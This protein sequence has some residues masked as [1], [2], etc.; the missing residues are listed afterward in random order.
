[1]TDQSRMKTAPDAQRA[2]VQAS[3]QANNPIRTAAM[4]VSATIILA[5]LY[6]GRGV[7]VP[8][9]LALLLSFA[10]NP[11]VSW[12]RRSGMPR[13][14]AVSAVMLI[15][16]CVIA[17]FGLIL[18][19]QV[20]TLS[21]ELPTYQSTIQGKLTTLRDTLKSPG[22]FDG[23]L[24]TLGTIQNEVEA[25]QSTVSVQRVEVLPVPES[26]LK[27]A[28]TWLA[29]SAEPLATAGIVFVFVFLA[30]LDSRDIRDRFLRM[31][32]GNLYRSTDAMDEAGARISKYLL[33]QLLVNVTY[34]APLA[35]GLWFIGVPGALLWG[36]VAAA[37]RFIPYVGPAISSIFPLALAFA[38]DPGWSMVLWTLSLIVFLELVSN[39]VVEPL[40]YGASTGLSAIALIAAATFWT[41][42]WGPIGLIL[43]TPLT[44]CLLV[45]GRH[46]PQLQF[47]DILLGSEPALDVPTRI[48]QRLIAGD[49]DEVIE[50]AEAE[51]EQSTELTF[52]DDVGLNV[53]RLASEDH[54]D[55]AS[56]EHRLRIVSGMDDLLDE[57]AEQNPPAMQSSAARDTVICIGGKWEVDTIAARMLGNALRHEGVAAASR[58]AASINAE[59]VANLDL[60]GVEMVCLSYFSPEPVIPARHFCRRL[61]RKWPNLKIMLALW[62]ARDDLL[63]DEA[64]K[65]LGA[66][67]V[68]T[69]I[70]EAVQ[71]IQQMLLPDGEPEYKLA[72]I[73]ED[74]ARRVE[75]LHA[76]GVLSGHAKEE[77]DAM[78]KRA[79]DV[80]NTGFAM[81]SL[82]D[83]DREIVAGKSGTLPKSLVEDSG[84]YQSMSREQS[85]CGHVVATGETLVVPDAERDPRFAD[86]P[87]ID[88]RDVRF[89][90]GAPLRTQDGFIL[91]TLCIVDPNPR[92]I[93]ES[94]IELLETMAADVTAL[95]TSRPA[96]IDHDEIEGASPNSA[97]L[98]QRVP[99]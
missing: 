41:A 7:L 16:L 55:V 76:T 97:T 92:A 84:P 20:R 85:I 4:L 86:N 27:Q 45:I 83:T 23:V 48:Y 74:D 13:I 42:L 34:G 65:R 38:V 52:Y 75:A 79:A 43:S 95:I 47:L 37:M 46:L 77:L 36:S 69:S 49:V 18:G 11:A 61:R 17:G 94:E 58:P 87:A 98:G 62:N 88:L 70:T 68:A 82:I 73:P 15:V 99:N 3:G 57:L 26:A 19:T 44:V 22:I 29:R 56:A 64:I 24:K 9:A 12:L 90:A 63:A 10:L 60:E 59:Y 78:A 30:L 2:L 72:P 71:R 40:L 35:L 67:E 53:L 96:Q 91:G 31:L 21:N 39:N 14:V 51:I 25:P 1:M 93:D 66:D 32:G 81:I 33:M 80:F 54:A 28:A 50:I 8:L 89:Y 6:Y 5:A